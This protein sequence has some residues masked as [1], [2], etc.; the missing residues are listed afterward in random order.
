MCLLWICLP[1][2]IPNILLIH[3][4][5]NTSEFSGYPR[6]TYH[7]VGASSTSIT[8]LCRQQSHKMNKTKS[9]GHLDYSIRDEHEIQGSGL[10]FENNLYEGI[11][12]SQ[13]QLCLPLGQDIFRTQSEYPFFFF[14]RTISYRPMARPVSAVIGSSVFTD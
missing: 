13:Y 11:L 14:I 3:G 10:F 9:F 8:S 1:E 6:E 4:A 5:G 7:S 12:P 2:G